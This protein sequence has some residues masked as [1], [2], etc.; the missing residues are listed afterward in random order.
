MEVEENTESAGFATDSVVFS[1]EAAQRIE[2]TA[3]AVGK[4]S[5]TIQPRR[6]GRN[7]HVC[8]PR[9]R[10]KHLFRPFG[11]RLK[12]ASTHGLRRGLYSLRRFAARNGTVP[13]CFVV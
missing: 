2:P 7:G 10:A 9:R 8:A 5:E 11:A 6:G 4:R 3:R 12:P 1:R 13:T